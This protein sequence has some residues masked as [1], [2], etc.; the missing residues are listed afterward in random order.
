MEQRING[1]TIRLIVFILI[2]GVLS[3]FAGLYAEWLWFDSVNFASVFTTIVLNKIA[4]YVTLFTF[5]FLLFYINLRITRKNMGLSERPEEDNEG[6]E[7]I[8]LDQE[9]P[10]PWRDFMQGPYTKW[11]FVGVSLF[12]GFI[13][14]S[15]AGDYWIVIQQ[16]LNRV[17]VGTVDP[18]FAKD[19]GFYFFNLNFYQFI[20]STL[21]TGLILVTITVGIIYALNASSDLLFGNWRQFTVAK[22][23]IAILIAFIFALKAWGYV[24]DSY[25]VLFSPEGI[26]FGATYTDIYA[27]L[28]AY[29][30][31]MVISI[32]ITLVIIINIFVK[33]F[34]L[35]L[36]S[37]GV[38]ILVA[39]FLGGLYPTLIQNF[40]VQPN[41]FNKERPY[42]ES[43]IKFTRAAYGLDNAE[44]QQFDVDNL[45]DI[46]DPDHKITVDNIRLWDWQPL[47]TTYK[48]LQQLRPY[49]VFDDVDVDRYI[50]DGN[51]RQVM[52]SAREI[53][54]A[55]LPEEAKTWINQKLMYTHGYGLVVSPVTEVA[56]EGFPE[57]FVKDI[58][59]RFSTDLK[60][61][62]PEIY[63]GEVTNNY[64]IVNTLQKEF[65]YPMGEQN[66][67]T[68]YEGNN[69]IKVNS[70]FRKLIFSW[71]LKDYK[72]ML[73]SQVTNDSQILMNRNIVNRVKMITPYL[74]YDSDPYIVINDDGKLYWMMDAYT[75]TNKY[76]YSEPFD[77]NRNNYLRNSVKV[78]VD[79]YTGDMNFYIADED[80]PIIKTYAA[81]FPDIYQPISEMPEGLRAH[82]RYPVDMFKIQANT[83]K[84]FH[85]TDPYVFY[86]K[87]DPWLI[88]TE[89]VDDKSQTME[90]YYIIMKL[91][92][93]EEAEYIL[94]LPFTPKSRPN[95]VGWMCARMDGDNYG[96][97]LVYNFPKQE[98]IYGPEQIES[99]IN[100]NTVIAQQL[101]LWDQRGSRVYR[102]N[103]LVIPMGNSILY[104]EPLYL[105]A[106]SSKLP[107]LKRVIAGFGNKTVMEPTLADALTSLFGRPGEE[108]VGG[109][110]SPPDDSEVS[111]PGSQ[112][113]AELAQQA[114]QYY[115]QAQESLSA[116]DWAG[117]GNNLNKLKDIL[118]QLQA[119][120]IED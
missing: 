43:A 80:D 22:S 46:Y 73:S 40:V 53:D 2:L 56:E 75:F 29:K 111:S 35:V 81:I 94:M 30:V 99:R 63:F 105:Q 7:V 84:T 95:M 47:M 23:H 31:L 48:N 24:L 34:N 109:E 85:M 70:I 12:G 65:D 15:V 58:P 26:V 72:M 82:V 52:L 96:K 87:E 36:I 21:M 60:I 117:Y 107:E 38:W 83:Y 17:A 3:L 59:P 45:L 101:S 39:I 74:S 57:F 55:E 1:S 104:V 90:P 108:P 37:I 106:D 44:N 66:V 32:I 41:E 11:I 6:R 100:Q 13:L 115:D 20:Y 28:I 54:Q 62:R 97:L 64:V 110:T 51:Y 9:R 86:N 4:L 98:T 5:G 114:K 10:S 79:A 120:V 119:S 112:S 67:Y 61:E 50:I 113:L 16:Y 76:P 69:G 92:G 8:Y 116:G 103:L 118:D 19:L 88:P 91:P 14:S 77:S 33:K 49:Y 102:G 18:I 25:G 93:E 71:V 27:R 78:T 89:V 42:I 68:T